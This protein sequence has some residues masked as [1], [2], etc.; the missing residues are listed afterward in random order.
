MLMHIG[1]ADDVTVERLRGDDAAI[2]AW[3]EENMADMVS[4]DKAWDVLGRAIAGND[5]AGIYQYC[6]GPLHDG[7]LGYGPT[8]L[9]E[10]D[11][12]A[13]LKTAL[14]SVDTEGMRGFLTGAA[15]QGGEAPYPYFDGIDPDTLDDDVEWIVGASQELLVL[16]AEAARA[17]HHLIVVML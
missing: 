13:T 7:D 5:A 17:R 14:E 10:P 3:L 6:S 16:A 2:E 11:R 9:M 1:R 15:F 4:L 12:V 8:I